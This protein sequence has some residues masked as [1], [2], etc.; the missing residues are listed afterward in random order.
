MEEIH[1]LQQEPPARGEGA[2][3]AGRRGRADRADAE[4]LADAQRALSPAYEQA[5]ANARAVDTSPI[6]LNLDSAAV[7]LR[8]EAQSIAKSLRDMLNVNGVD[9]LDPNPRTL[10]EVR[11]AIDGMFGTVQDGNARRILSETR[12]LVDDELSRAVPGIK[13]A[14]AQFAQLAQQRDAFAQGQTSLDSGRSA[15]TPEDLRQLVAGSP[16][17]VVDAMSQGARAEIDRIIGT[18][19]NNLTAL[20]SAVK[21]DG[22][23][24]RDRLATLFGKDKADQLLNVLEREQRFASSFDTV[25]RN[26]ETAA[27]TAAQKEAAPREFDI[28]IQDLVTGIPQ[29]VANAGARWRS[30]ATNKAIAEMLMGRPSR[31]VVDQL[32][33]A[34]AAQ[35]GL[36]GA[37]PVPLLTNR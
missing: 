21:G 9:A 6:A 29:K 14:D 37:A 7:N 3:T 15:L 26:S 28:R 24:N 18:T 8:G 10:F 36:I 33:A 12:K 17:S 4:L 31:D 32:I 2:E 13:D 5:F 23:W 30:E 19:G 34:R 20:K 22:S 25:T 16:V 35:R 1:F 27:R 11:K